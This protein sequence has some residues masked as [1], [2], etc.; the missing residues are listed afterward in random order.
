MVINAI[1]RKIEEWQRQGFGF[2][3]L[4]DEYNSML[5]IMGEDV[6][7]RSANGQVLAQGIVQGVDEC[8]RLVVLQ[9]GVNTLVTVG[10]VTL[11]NP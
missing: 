6:T 8:G 3:G 2:A 4:K 7:V 1:I 11:R 5:S 10:D 9:G